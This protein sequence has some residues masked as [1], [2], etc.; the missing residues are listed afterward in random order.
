[1]SSIYYYEQ[2]GMKKINILLIRC[3]MPATST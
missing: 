2:N 3:S 1:M